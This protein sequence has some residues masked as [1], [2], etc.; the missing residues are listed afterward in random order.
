M[1]RVVLALV[2]IEQQNQ[3]Y[4]CEANDLGVVWGSG[5]IVYVFTDIGTLLFLSRGFG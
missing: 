1:E 4:N 2:Y 5:Q 3:F